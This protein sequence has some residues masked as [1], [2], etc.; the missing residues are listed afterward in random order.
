MCDTPHYLPL[1]C[2]FR[3]FEQSLS[4]VLYPLIPYGIGAHK[5]KVAVGSSC[6]VK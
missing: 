2:L 1:Q 3:Q 6:N 4:M 5:H